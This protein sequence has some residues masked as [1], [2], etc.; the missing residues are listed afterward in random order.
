MQHSEEE[1]ELVELSAEELATLRHDSSQLTLPAARNWSSST[2][3]C[4]S[5]PASC[6]L[7][8][9]CPCLQ[10]GLNQRAAFGSSCAKWTVL[11]VLPLLLLYLLVDHYYPSLP[12]AEKAAELAMKHIEDG[13][14][15]PF[16]RG[17]A[18]LYA[19]P[20]AMILMGCVGMFRRRALR[21]KYGIGGNLLGD[22]L[23]HCLCACCSLA[24]E[25]REIRKQTLDEV[26]A[27]AEQDLTS[28]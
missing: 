3:V 24:R 10:F 25:A 12:T 18:F 16:D 8:C 11:Y 21:L 22:F 13:D 17:D 27:G 6:I 26:V 15:E 20:I 7:S 5:S 28:V 2:F 19:M 23:C 1:E 4:C 9:C 14:E